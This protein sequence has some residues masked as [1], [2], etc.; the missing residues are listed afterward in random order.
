MGMSLPS[1]LRP[2]S[3][4]SLMTAHALLHHDGKSNWRRY[5]HGKVS[6]RSRVGQQTRC[7]ETWPAGLKTGHNRIG[8]RLVR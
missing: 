6:S 3:L 7:R 8:E 1:Y 4:I 5:F 2:S